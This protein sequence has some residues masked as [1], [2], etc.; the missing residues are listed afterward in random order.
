MNWGLTYKRLWGLT[1]VFW[2]FGLIGSFLYY[3]Q[4]RLDKSAFV[5]MTIILSC[6]TLLAVNIANFDYLIY[7]YG[8]ANTAQGV[9]YDYLS[10]LSSDSLSYTTQIKNLNQL[11]TDGGA[12]NKFRYAFVDRKIK[13]LQNKYSKIDLRTFNLSEYRQ[14]LEIQ[15]SL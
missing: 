12:V 14:Y 2:M 9:D 8:K 10:R 11:S 7:H 15:N 6:L 4:K 13:Y 3:H 5:K 1:G